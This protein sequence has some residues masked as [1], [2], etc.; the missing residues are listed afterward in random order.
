MQKNKEEKEHELNRMVEDEKR[1]KLQE[2]IDQ[3]KLE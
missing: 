1:R 2:I 3:R